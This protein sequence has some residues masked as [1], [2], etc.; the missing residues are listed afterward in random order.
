M[1]KGKL[2][3]TQARRAQKKPRPRRVPKHVMREKKRRGMTTVL[4]DNF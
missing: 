3:Q 1:T 2:L 4:V